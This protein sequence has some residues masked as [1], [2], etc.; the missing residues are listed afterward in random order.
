AA[1]LAHF[2]LNAREVAGRA[3][4]VVLRP[5]IERMAVASRALKPHAQKDLRRRLRARRWVTSCAVIIGRRARISTAA[6]RD[7][8]SREDVERFRL[9]E[10]AADPGEKRLGAVR[11]PRPSPVRR[12]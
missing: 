2:V 7:D 12:G 5:T 10:G 1:F 11:R 4:V 6:A 3:V 9:L 8:L